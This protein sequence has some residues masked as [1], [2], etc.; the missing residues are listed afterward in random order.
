MS[1]GRSAAKFGPSQARE[2]AQQHERAVWRVD[3]GG[4]VV[5]L[6]DGQDWPLRR[7]FLSSAF[8]PAGVAA[9]G[10]R[11]WRRAPVYPP[12]NPPMPSAM[13]SSKSG[14]TAPGVWSDKMTKVIMLASEVTSVDARVAGRPRM[15]CGLTPSGPGPGTRRLRARRSRPRTQPRQPARPAPEPGSAGPDG[16]DCPGGRAW[17]GQPGTQR[18]QDGGDHQAED[19][20][21]RQQLDADDRSGDDAGHG[22]GDEHHGQAAA[23]LSLPPVPVE[24][25]GCRDDV[26]QQVGRGDGRAGVPS[27][28]TWNG[29]SR[30]APEI[31]AGV[32][33]AEIRKA[34]SRATS[35][36][37]PS[38]STQPR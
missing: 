18:Q 6:R 35:S 3:R 37:Q 26:V 20:R 30:T 32:V 33:S 36:V 1:Q 11:D 31:P 28:L 29:S 25:A 22:P 7:L 15:A 13:P 4:Q 2:G 21:T 17:S 10:I 27:T 38:G 34:A 24:H 9:D 23:G 8:D 19:A 12:T 14:A 16:R 5:D